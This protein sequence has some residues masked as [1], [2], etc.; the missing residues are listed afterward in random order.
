MRRI[1]DACAECGGK[2]HARGMCGMHYARWLKRQT[3]KPPRE[4]RVCSTCGDK[5]HAMGLCHKHYRQAHPEVGARAEFRCPADLV[6]DL[7]RL[8]AEYKCSNAE[9]IRMAIEW[10]LESCAH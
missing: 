10:G 1:Y 6:A 9:A 8:A 2:H 4:V 5:H 7:K 3:P